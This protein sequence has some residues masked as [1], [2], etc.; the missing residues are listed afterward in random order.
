MEENKDFYKWLKRGSSTYLP[1]GLESFETVVQ[2]GLYFIKSSTKMGIYLEKRPHKHDELLR[3]PM[4]ELE[5]VLN[6]IQNF[7]NKEDNFKRYDFVFKRGILLY[8]VPGG[9]KTCIVNLVI[10]DLIEKR[11][12][13]VFMLT[14][15]RD[16][17]LY[18]EFMPIFRQIQP[19]TPVVTIIE[20][21]DGLCSSRWLE[22]K[23]LNILDGAEQ[24]DK[25][26]YL[27]TTNYPERLKAR[28]TNRPSRFDRRYEI[29]MPNAE[30]RE[31][32]IRAKLKP[33][34]LPNVNMDMWVRETEEMTLSHIADLIKSVIV[35][36]MSFEE[37]IEALKDMRYVPHSDE[38]K[39]QMIKK[40]EALDN[41][42]S[43]VLLNQEYE[44]VLENEK[45]N[46]DKEKYNQNNFFLLRN[47]NK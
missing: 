3:L 33:E 2:P 21:I 13:V 37:T 30:V 25:I 24:L 22:T 35:L 18:A 38:F 40:N 43:K 26:V 36:G 46:F 15:E 10:Q 23:L 12:G 7:W 19:D 1:A 8:G 9:G 5:I 6:D 42:K 34:D 27:A 44:D 11:N 39:G 45:Y 14:E 4:E 28:I 32:Y 16:L 20:D 29:K 41:E 17:S 47:L 31:A